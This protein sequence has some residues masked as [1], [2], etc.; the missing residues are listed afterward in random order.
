MC[1]LHTA[2]GAPYD[3]MR[4]AFRGNLALGE[5]IFVAEV[6]SLSGHCLRLA[7]APSQGLTI[8]IS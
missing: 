2:A 5:K 7:G 6:G 1:T 8:D 3:G 4:T